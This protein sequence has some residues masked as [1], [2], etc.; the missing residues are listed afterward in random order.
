ME[1]WYEKATIPYVYARLG[2][3]FRFDEVNDPAS[4]AAAANGQFILIRR[5]AYQTSG[6]PRQ[7]CGA[8]FGRCGVGGAGQGRRAAHLVWQWKGNCAR[9]DVPVFGGHV[10][11]LEE[12]SVHA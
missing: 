10:G 9:P 8:R 6:W 1:T 2:S 5:D 11:G 7:H 4:S 12:E 3:R